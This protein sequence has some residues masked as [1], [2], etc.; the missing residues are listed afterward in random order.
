MYE[1]TNRGIL[2]LVRGLGENEASR[3]FSRMQGAKAI[4]SVIK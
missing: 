2:L 3:S 1:R 4:I